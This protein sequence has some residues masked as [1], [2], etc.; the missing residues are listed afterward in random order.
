MTD[1]PRGDLRAGPD[2]RAVLDRGRGDR[3]RQRHDLRPGRRGLD[4]R[5]RSR[6]AG[7]RPAAPRDGLDQRLQHVPA[8][9][10]MGRLQAVGDRPRARAERP[11]RVPRGQA[12]LAEHRPGPD[13]LVRGLN[14]KAPRVAEA[15]SLQCGRGR[16]LLRW[17]LRVDRV[18]VDALRAAIEPGG[19][20]QQGRRAV[21]D[22]EELDR[23][24]V[25]DADPVERVLEPQRRSSRPRMI[26][27]IKPAPLMTTRR[28]R[29][30]RVV[31]D[32]RLVPRQ[33]RR[34]D[35]AAEEGD[36]DD[37]R[38]VQGQRTERR[39]STRRSR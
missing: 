20:I 1:H 22:A 9:G 13:R 26:E 29:D 2:G 16:A 35:R 23:V 38:G 31:E 18:E 32:R 3:A 5:R 10:R 8:A 12:H 25:A 19:D 11:R 36:R 6:P 14:R 4:G 34:G 33:D 28:C 15:P 37:Q 21:D 17:D 24:G 39:L 27:V 7:R 30:R